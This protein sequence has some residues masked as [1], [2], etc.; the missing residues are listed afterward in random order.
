MTT[1]VSCSIW[2]TNDA[3]LDKIL[4]LQTI[5]SLN[6]AVLNDAIISIIRPE[7]SSN[8][9]TGGAATLTLTFPTDISIESVRIVS[10]SRIQEISRATKD[11]E[12][13]GSLGNCEKLDNGLWCTRLDEFEADVSAVNAVDI[14]FLSLP[15][16][17]KDVLQIQSIL[18]I[19]EGD[20]S[21]PSGTETRPSSLPSMVASISPQLVGQMSA[22]L[23]QLDISQ[24]AA[25]DSSSSY[26]KREIEEKL[27][28]I[29]FDMTGLINSK[30]DSLEA[31][32]NARFD[33]LKQQ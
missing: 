31:L 14:K 9:D 8:S 23:G 16:D 10:N 20:L 22:L 13:L 27:E 26:S 33:A 4:T 29:R 21:A 2:T 17:S 3:T 12:Y 32:I 18:V 7:T 28:R 6:D 24:K 19:V 30:F 11:Q 15:K 1:K 5:N 25:S